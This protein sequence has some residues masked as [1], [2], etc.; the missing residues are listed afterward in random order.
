[1]ASTRFGRY[2]INMGGVREVLKSGPVVSQL[3]GIAVPIAAGCNAS[4]Y[5]DRGSKGHYESDETPFN[6]WTSQGGYTAFGHVST[7]NLEGL[8][9]ENKAKVLESYNH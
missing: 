7:V 2:V 1:M 9:F 4:C 8:K 6:A 5:A 3:R